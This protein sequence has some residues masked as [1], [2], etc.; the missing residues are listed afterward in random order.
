LRSLLYDVLVMVK[1]LDFT[2]NS[3]VAANSCIGRS[4]GQSRPT[5]TPT[6]KASKTK[7]YDDSQYLLQAILLAEPLPLAHDCAC[8]LHV[9]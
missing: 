8:N 6:L 1:N 2:S 3:L 7:I 5:K 4:T 9:T